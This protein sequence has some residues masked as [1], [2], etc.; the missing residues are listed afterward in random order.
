MKDNQELLILA[1]PKGRVYEE[2]LPVLKDSEF[3]LK[4]DPKK[5]RKLVL[6]TNNNKVKILLVRGWDVPAYVTSGAAHL[7]IVGKDILIEKDSEE[8]I[9]LKDLEMGKC[10]LSLAGKKDLLSGSTRMKIATKYP[11]SSIKF[12]ESIGIQSEIIYLHGAQEIA[13]LMGLSDAII[14]LVE[15]GKTL[16]DNGLQ[17]IKV[18]RN[19]STRLIANKAAL[20]TKSILIQRLQEIF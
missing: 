15:S 6:D 1:L 18:I 4:D 19:I 12:M 2:V 10:R 13:P 5:T 3:E 9:E 17:E 14:D 7:G 16:K 11:K 8:F 20:K